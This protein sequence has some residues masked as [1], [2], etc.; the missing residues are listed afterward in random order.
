MSFNIIQ[1]LK[2]LYVFSQFQHP[3]MNLFY[4]YYESIS[5]K[6]YLVYILIL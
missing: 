1:I 2:N 6:K 5:Y 4:N 3:T